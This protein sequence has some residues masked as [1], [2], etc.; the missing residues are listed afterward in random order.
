MN[1]QKIDDNRSSLE[2]ISYF[3]KDNGIFIINC[4]LIYQSVCGRF[5]FSESM[6]PTRG[7]EP[8][9]VLNLEADYVSSSSFC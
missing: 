1:R 8:K 7:T 6:N 2:T 9:T 4:D 5:N 3:A